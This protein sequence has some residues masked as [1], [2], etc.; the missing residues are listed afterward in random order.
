MNESKRKKVDTSDRVDQ[1]PSNTE[2]RDY[3]HAWDELLQ[4]VGLSKEQAI[5]IWDQQGRPV[6]HLGLCENCF[7]LAKLLTQ[8]SAKSAHVVA[9]KEWL[10]KHKKQ[11]RGEKGC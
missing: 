8:K 5:S 2:A 9:V 3:A 6:I 1:K 11:N 7:D 10:V 4:E